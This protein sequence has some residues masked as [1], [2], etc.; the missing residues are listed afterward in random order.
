MILNVLQR[1]REILN[2]SRPINVKSVVPAKPFILYNKPDFN[3]RSLRIGFDYKNNDNLSFYT[4]NRFIN[5]N[6]EGKWLSLKIDG[7]YSITIYN[8]PDFGL[9]EDSEPPISDDEKLKMSQTTIVGADNNSNNDDDEG[10]PTKPA[11]KS[12]FKVIESPGIEDVRA[13]GE[14]WNDGISL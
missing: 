1:E 14:E 10:E 13:L 7:D 8:K 9:E 2:G 11:L 3:G 4:K 12:L 5:K 6:G